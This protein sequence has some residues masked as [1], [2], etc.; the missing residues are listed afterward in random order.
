[1]TASALLTGRSIAWLARLPIAAAVSAVMGGGAFAGSPHDDFYWIGEMNKASAVMVVSTGIVDPRL[2]RNIAQAIDKVNA[3]SDKP[4][5]ARP[6]DY[7]EVEPLL[8][9]AGGPDVTRRRK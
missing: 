2:G 8:I 4:G 3:D 1:M 9:A 6:S 7:F 5:A